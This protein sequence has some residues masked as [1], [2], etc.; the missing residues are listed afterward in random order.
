[1]GAKRASHVVS[2]VTNVV[3]ATVLAIMTT[4]NARYRSGETFWAKHGASVAVWVSV[5]LVAA[6]PTRH[7]LQDA[8]LWTDE[9]SMMY[10]SNCDHADVRCLSV[11]GFTF[12]MFTYV[13]FACML[14]G[15]FVS[16]GAA[17]KLSNGWRR[18]R[19]GR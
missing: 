14:G 12:L 17:G 8:G 10:R 13:G 4:R 2:L 3:A 9:S 15:V 7:V 19:R 18:V 11:T 1:M 6:D 5:P 16:T